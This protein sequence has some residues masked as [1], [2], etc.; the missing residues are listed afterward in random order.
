M[1]IG[2]STLSMPCPCCRHD[3]AALFI[4]STVVTVRCTACGYSWPADALRL[5]EYIQRAVT[6]IVAARRPSETHTH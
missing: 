5:P 3:E 6:A 4:S 1:P 2:P